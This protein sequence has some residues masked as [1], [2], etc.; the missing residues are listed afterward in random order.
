MNKSNMNLNPADKFK[1]ADDVKKELLD[2]KKKGMYMHIYGEMYE[3]IKICMYVYMY[4][5]V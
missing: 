5:C 2:F 3:Y 4:V 1:G